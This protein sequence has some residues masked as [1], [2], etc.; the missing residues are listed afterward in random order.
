[1][2]VPVLVEPI[3]ILDTPQGSESSGVN[4]VVEKF[5]N[6]RKLLHVKDWLGESKMGVDLLVDIGS[7]Y[8]LI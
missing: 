1:M 5:A 3:V 7:A 8:N 2:G 4:V 6:R